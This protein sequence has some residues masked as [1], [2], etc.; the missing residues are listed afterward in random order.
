MCD[1]NLTMTCPP[2]QTVCT[3]DCKF[4][5]CPDPAEIRFSPQPR[6]DQFKFGG[7]ISAQPHPLNDP[8]TNP[9]S[10]RLENANGTIYSVDLAAGDMI[11]TGPSSFIFENPNARSD[12]GVGLLKIRKGLQGPSLIVFKCY[13]DLSAATLPHMKATLT[14]GDQEFRSEGDWR[15]TSTGWFGAHFERQGP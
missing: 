6:P 1:M 3:F 14:I 11:P 12:G 9:V 13:G 2:R 4:V 10:I 8:S 15:Q 5:M 7:R